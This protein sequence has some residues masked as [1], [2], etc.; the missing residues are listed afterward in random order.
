MA[1][2]SNNAQD[3]SYYA[4]VVDAFHEGEGL[5]DQYAGFGPFFLEELDEQEANL[6]AFGAEVLAEGPLYW[7]DG[8][9]AVDFGVT[10]IKLAGTVP[11]T[12]DQKPVDRAVIIH[13]DESRPIEVRYLRSGIE[14]YYELIGSE[15]LE[16]IEPAHDTPPAV[17][18]WIGWRDEDSK[19]KGSPINRRATNLGAVIGWSGHPDDHLNGTI[20]FIGSTE[21][22]DFKD[23]PE[24]LVTI[25]AEMR[26]DIQ[27]YDRSGVLEDTNR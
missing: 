21:N 6:L 25:C 22:G 7:V 20:V 12:R 2:E 14:E 13:A 1:E 15:V 11:V 5:R 19:R 26:C 4:L 27:S 24:I 3:Q 18:G 23:V 10:R 17:S 9:P 16:A 8:T